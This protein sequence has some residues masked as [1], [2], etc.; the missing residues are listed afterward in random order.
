MCM[1]MFYKMP[2]DA[3]FPLVL[4][5]H[6]SITSLNCSMQI[7]W[8]WLSFT[9]SARIDNLQLSHW[10]CY[11]LLYLI[12]WCDSGNGNALSVDQLCFSKTQVP[13]LVFFFFQVRVVNGV[14]PTGDYS[15]AKYNKVCISNFFYQC[16]L[17]CII[18]YWTVPMQFSFLFLFF[19]GEMIHIL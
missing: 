4:E 7:T 9:N 16:V 12:W 13:W 8:Q 1:C 14:P 18:I 2:I 5:H 6:V 11:L 15:F 17:L 3:F 19:L 10:V